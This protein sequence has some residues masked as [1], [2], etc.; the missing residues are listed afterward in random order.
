MCNAHLKLNVGL[1]TVSA[2]NGQAVFGCFLLDHRHSESPRYYTMAELQLKRVS[3]LKI[4]FLVDNSIEWFAR[5]QRFLQELF[6]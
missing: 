6:Y 4:T 1:Y 5:V 3:K 2:D